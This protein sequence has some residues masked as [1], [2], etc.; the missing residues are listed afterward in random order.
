MKASRTAANASKR[1]LLERLAVLDPLLELDR[2]RGELLVGER[3]ELGLER[4]DVRGL[5]G[6]PL[7]AAALAEAQDLLESCPVSG[8][9]CSEE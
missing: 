8:A 1:T 4:P 9:I 5:L 2:L 7:Q 6:E 3:L